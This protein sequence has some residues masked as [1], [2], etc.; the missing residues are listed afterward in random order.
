[1]IFSSPSF[2]L[3]RHQMIT[4]VTPLNMVSRSGEVIFTGQNQ[5]MCFFQ[6]NPVLTSITKQGSIP[7]I[8]SWSPGLHYPPPT[9]SKKLY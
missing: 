6:P 4:Q 1:M 3:S 8:H 7:E 5:N 2:Q 9:P